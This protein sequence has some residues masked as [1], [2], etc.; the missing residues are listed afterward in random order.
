MPHYTGKGPSAKPRRLQL[1]HP[2][3]KKKAPTPQSGIGSNVAG[4]GRTPRRQKLSSTA[5]WRNERFDT[6]DEV[7]LELRIAREATGAMLPLDDGDWQ[8]SGMTACRH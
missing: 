6:P 8:N 3:L 7:P 4:T 1:R 2:A 5:Y